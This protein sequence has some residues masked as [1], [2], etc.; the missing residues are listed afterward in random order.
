MA[1]QFLLFPH[2]CKA[3]LKYSR[4]QA[5]NDVR[6]YHEPNS[7]GRAGSEY[8]TEFSE[9]VVPISDIGLTQNIFGI[10]LISPVSF[11]V[12]FLSLRFYRI[13]ANSRKLLNSAKKEIR[14]MGVF[15]G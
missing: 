2:H 8:V 11:Y 4:L 1:Q 6:P 3:G 15:E 10:V 5:I 9:D 14:Q 12:L 13:E 7:P